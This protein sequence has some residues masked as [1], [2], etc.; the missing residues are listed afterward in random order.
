[1]HLPCVIVAQESV[2]VN[3]G[4]VY[5]NKGG[6]HCWPLMLWSKV[7][8]LDSDAEFLH[9]VWFATVLS[10]IALAGEF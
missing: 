9:R 10:K 3:K 8:G 5:S 6:L 1:M 2:K 4:V 7:N